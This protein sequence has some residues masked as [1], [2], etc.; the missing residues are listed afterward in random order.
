VCS[1][2]SVFHGI[3]DAMRELDGP[4]FFALAYRLDAYQGAVTAAAMREAGEG[5]VVDAEM[6]GEE[7]GYPIEP[8][9]YVEQSGNGEMAAQPVA[10]QPASAGPDVPALT[11]EQLEAMFPAAPQIG[12]EV[13]L[14]EVTR[15]T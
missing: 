11:A 12:Q 9:Q 3:R 13:G 2:L 6:Y 5:P 7:E 15:C 8:P 1:D 4:T 10:V 14:F